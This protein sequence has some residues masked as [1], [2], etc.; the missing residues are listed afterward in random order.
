MPRSTFTRVP[1]LFLRVCSAVA[2]ISGIV[3]MPVASAAAPPKHPL[4]EAVKK[5]DEEALRKLF[6]QRVDVNGAE[7]DGTTA[8]HWAAYKNDLDIVKLLIQAGANV[9]AANR[10]GV[11]PMHLAATAGN[12]AMVE[13]LL[14]AGADPNEALPEGE[15]ALMTAARSGSAASVKVLIARGAHA[16]AREEWRGQT[17]LMWA[18]AEGH[19]DVVQL[20]IAAGADV[21]V[22]SKGAVGAGRA[23]VAEV[24]G[25]TASPGASATVASSAEPPAPAAGRAARRA[26]STVLN[27]TPLLFAVRAGQMETV[28]AL[29]DAGA[30]ANEKVSDGTSA[31]TLAILNAHYELAAL[32]AASGANPN[33]GDQGWTALHQL[34]WTR[35]PNVGRPPPAP[36]ATGNLD[37]LE[38]ARVLLK[39]GAD[40]NARQKKEPRDNNRNAMNRIDATP[41]LLAAKAA[42]VEMMRVLL[43]GGAD[44]KLTTVEG[45]TPLMAAA[46]VGI[47]KVGESPG[48]GEE[49]LEAVRFLRE[50]GCDVNAVDENGDTAMHGA[51]F[52]GYPLL[53]QYLFDQGAKL[54]VKNKKD[55]TPLA[56]ADGIF[57]ISVFIRNAETAE[58]LRKL[59]AAEPTTRQQQ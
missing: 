25:P 55:L 30:D 51:A 22:R 26:A 6:R 19:T 56:I 32:L 33:L 29:L 7:V 4:V 18:A 17:A 50:L 11:T 16:D 40:P 54:D 10:Y 39:H 5:A 3:S 49:A 47:Y 38:L 43:E 2:I 46:G 1:Q 20:L 23:Q 44:T 31:I 12:A 13:T 53:V 9:K 57:H 59:G 37:S 27:F 21:H 35:R 42:D 58:L 34:V 45:I 24:A 14:N 15:T 52:R 28:R 36:V 48:T 8:L 41:F